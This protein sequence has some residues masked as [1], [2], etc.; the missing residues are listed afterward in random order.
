MGYSA[1]PAEANGAAGNDSSPSQKNILACSVATCLFIPLTPQ[2]QICCPKVLHPMQNYNLSWFIFVFYHSQKI[3]GP[4]SFHLQGTVQVTILYYCFLSQCTDSINLKTNIFIYNLDS[5][6]TK[7][8]HVGDRFRQCVYKS[9]V[10]FAHN[11][12]LVL[13]FDPFVYLVQ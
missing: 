1:L 13:C 12:F 11:P 9:T 4:I 8:Y 7:T 2:N 5:N 10:K 6:S 3:Y